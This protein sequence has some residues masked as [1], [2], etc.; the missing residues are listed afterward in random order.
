M[1]VWVAVSLRNEAIGVIEDGRGVVIQISVNDP[2]QDP[3]ALRLSSRRS[4]LA[5]TKLADVAK[6]RARFPGLE[7]AL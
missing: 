1:L 2:L 6:P 4:A 7:T 3:P 5:G